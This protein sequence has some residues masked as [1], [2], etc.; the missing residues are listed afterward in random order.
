VKFDGG[1][2]VPH[3]FFLLVPG[4]EPSVTPPPD[5]LPDFEEFGGD[6]HYRG[7]T[8]GRRLF[9]FWPIDFTVLEVPPIPLWWQHAIHYVT[10]LTEKLRSVPSVIR[11]HTV[12]TAA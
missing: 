2:F 4:S 8:R 6:P 1:A 11:I 3:R 7:D 9:P 12:K 10:L 5:D